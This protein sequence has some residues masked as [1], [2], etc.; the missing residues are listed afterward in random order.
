MPTIAIIGPGAIGGILAAWLAQDASNTVTVCARTPFERLEVDTPT[1]QISASPR[2]V[3]D[4]ARAHAVDWVLVAT[5]AYDAATAARWFP[6]VCRDDTPV[7]IL[8]NGVEHVERFAPYV[9]VQRLVP[10]V[11]DCPA[12]RT[13]PG[14]M[15]QRGPS[16]IVVPDS[17]H[18]R[19]FVPL[20]AKTNFDVSTGDFGTRAWAKLCINAPGAISAILM[21]PTGVIQIDPIPELT[22]GIVRECLAVGRAEGA[23]LDDAIV[24]AV[25]EGA[26]NAPP[27]SLNSLIADR[28]AGR[29]MEI[30]ARNGAIVRLGRK[31]GIPTPL[32][33]MAVALLT[34]AQDTRS[35]ER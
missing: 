15:R 35:F 19:A 28:M 26:R 5:K 23:A 3:T 29:P 13:A 16:W 2:V 33:E 31:H 30:D 34:A 21:K 14:R 11:I 24:D 7:V 17:A 6:A 8:Q 12:E 20:F 18:G 9:P 25:V 10:A 22:R 27:D 1:G 32:N 4:P